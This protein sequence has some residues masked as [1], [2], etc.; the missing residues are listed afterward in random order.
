LT[1]G[2]CNAQVRKQSII[3]LLVLERNLLEM[4]DQLFELI[5]EHEGYNN[6]IKKIIDSYQYTAFMALSLN[7]IALSLSLIT[8]RFDSIFIGC[9][10][11]AI[12]LFQVLLPCANGHLINTQNEKLLNAVNDFPWYELSAK[13]RKIFLQF[14][15]VCQHTEKL[16]LPIIGYVDMELFTNFVNASYSYFMVMLK[17]AKN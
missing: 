4:E 13:K 8:I 17:F 2:H 6:Y 14:V 7:S 16:T 1:F 15:M 5:K 12:L 9:A 3:E 10:L 11:S